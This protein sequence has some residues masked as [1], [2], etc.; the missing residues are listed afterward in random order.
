MALLAYEPNPSM[1]FQRLLQERLEE[2]VLVERV[3]VKV[4]FL[5]DLELFD[6]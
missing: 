4:D 2:Q 1:G 3:L 5:T 6:F